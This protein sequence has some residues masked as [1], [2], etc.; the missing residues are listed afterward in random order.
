MP[1]HPLNLYTT[2]LP[3]P[4]FMLF[5]CMVPSQTV[6]CIKMLRADICAA[7]GRWYRFVVLYCKSYPPSFP[8]LYHY[9]PKLLCQA[10]THRLQLFY[11]AFSPPPVAQATVVGGCYFL[12][13]HHYPLQGSLAAHQKRQKK[14]MRWSHTR[15]PGHHRA[16]H[17]GQPGLL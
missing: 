10:A 12:C 5:P 7:T 9:D 13:G 3:Y 11:P 17:L 15:H 14:P 1:G 8:Y 2:G 4:H 16:G 6:A